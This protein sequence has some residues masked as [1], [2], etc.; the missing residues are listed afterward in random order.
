MYDLLR[1][2]LKHSGFLLFVLFESI[3]LYLIVNYNRPQKEI[4]NYSTSVFSSYMMDKRASVLD[5][6]NL[7]EVNKQL[8]QR[9]AD[10]VAENMWL[11]SM[12]GNA[13]A[14]ELDSSMKFQMIPAKVISNQIGSRHN[15]FLINKGRKDKIKNNMGV[16]FNGFP[17][18]IVQKTTTNY[19]DVISILNPS[20]N[21]SVKLGNTNIIGNLQWSQKAVTTAKL[22]NIPL[23]IKPFVGDSV[24]T[25]G[26]SIVFPADLYVGVVKEVK[27]P[28]GTN[29]YDIEVGLA[30]NIS[31][32]EFVDVTYTEVKNEIDSL[33][34]E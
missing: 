19:A 34:S 30:K 23:H 29:Y 10:L 11:R 31:Q 15:H 6:F 28:L 24:L 20:F 7:D 26:Y 22:L 25:S 32:M 14:M 13:S 33:L 9:N 27:K 8:A 4:F 5:Y 3:A 1:Y 17:C 21:L 2:I 12:V 18:G 16:L